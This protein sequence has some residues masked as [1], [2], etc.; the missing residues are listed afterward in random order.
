MD[1]QKTCYKKL[2]TH[3]ESHAS[4]VSLLE[5]GEQRYIKWINNL[6]WNGVYYGIK[7]I[8]YY[9]MVSTVLSNNYD[10][11]W[12]GIYYGMK[13]IIYHSMVSIMVSDVIFIMVW[14]LLWYQI[15]IFHHGMVFIMVAYIYI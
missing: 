14:Y 1:I 9:N 11:S 13:Y 3:V 12:H 7:Y 5:R 15:I 6:L 2:F 4:A 10:L 8:I